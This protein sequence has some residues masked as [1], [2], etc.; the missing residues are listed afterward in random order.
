M[1]ICWLK[2]WFLSSE[3]TCIKLY[4]QFVFALTR[5]DVIKYISIINLNVCKNNLFQLNT[6]LQ[7]QCGRGDNEYYKKLLNGLKY[8]K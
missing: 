3:L 1:S 4:G 8:K 2:R 5:A 6:G 7:N